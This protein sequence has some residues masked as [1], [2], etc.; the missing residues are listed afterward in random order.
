MYRTSITPSLAAAFFLTIAVPPNATADTM[1]T[2]TDQRLAAILSDQSADTK[3][4]YPWR[5]PAET[6]NFCQI[7]EGD[8]IIETLPGGGWYSRILYPYLGK[9]G[10]LIGAQ[11]P[12]SLFKRF[13]WDETRLQTVL[14]RDKNWAQSIT[15]EP[16]AE[17]GAIDIYTMTQMPKR[18][19]GIADKV[20]FIRSLHNLKRFGDETGYVKDTL[21]EAFRSLKPG[22]IVCVVQHR[23]SETASDV[24]ANGSNGYLKQSVVIAAFETAGFKLVETSEMNANPKDRPSENDSVWR[25]PPVLRGSKENTAQ[26]RANKEIGESTRMTLR[27]IKPPT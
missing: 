16:V 26:W 27:F 2:P 9:S 10:R 4:R 8:T 24:W 22:G 23:A 13:G 19:D 12:L 14:D 21:N 11:Y 6:M 3:L 18:Y 17:G 20:L 1:G 25:L 5:R 15:S 7:Q